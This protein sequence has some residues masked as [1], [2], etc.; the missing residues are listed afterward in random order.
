[1]RKLKYIKYKLARDIEQTIY[2][3][4]GLN[5]IIDPRN[6]IYEDLNKIIKS[7]DELH[8][9]ND[10]FELQYINKGLNNHKL[11]C[12]YVKK[13][14]SNYTYYFKEVNDDLSFYDYEIKTKNF[15][16]SNYGENYFS[17][18]QKSIKYDLNN[19]LSKVDYDSIIYFFRV[20]ASI[21]KLFKFMSIESEYYTL[22]KC[23]VILFCKSFEDAFILS[24]NYF[25][26]FSDFSIY[27]KDNEGLLVP[28]LL[29]GNSNIIFPKRFESKKYLSELDFPLFF[30][31][32]NTKLFDIFSIRTDISN[33]RKL[34]K[35]LPN[36]TISTETGLSNRRKFKKILID[37]TFS[38]LKKEFFIQ[39]VRDIVLINKNAKIL[40]N[41]K[42]FCDN[43]DLVYDF[44]ICYNVDIDL[45]NIITVTD[46]DN[47]L[48]IYY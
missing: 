37:K 13:R 10:N 44:F 22:S 28:M 6:Q 33:K 20:D 16:S 8:F 32:Y 19:N 30:K 2:F 1:M 36:I 17:E 7:F 18:F 9:S 39:L 23:Q 26:H 41:Y 47:I 35:T 34:K 46:I 29:K 15:Q 25:P 24:Q 38:N 27:E 48:E 31:L 45:S 11:V 3:S 4:K 21:K 43:K 40:I 12:N 5:I 14:F 42:S